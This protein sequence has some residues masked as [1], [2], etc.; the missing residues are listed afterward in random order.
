MYKNV[1]TLFRSPEGMFR[2]EST[3]ILPAVLFAALDLFLDHVAGY[4]HL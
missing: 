2:Y 3:A 1:V 4:S